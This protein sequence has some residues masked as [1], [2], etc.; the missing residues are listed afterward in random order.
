[1]FKL[2]QI[3]DKNEKSGMVTVRFERPEACGNCHACGYGSKS[4]EI[5]I[6][7]DHNVGD[8]VRVEFPENRFLQ[9]TALVYVIPLAGLLLGLALGWFLSDGNDL[10]TILSA[11][12]GLGVSFAALY[13]VDKSISKKPGWS[14]RITGVYADK[15]TGEEPGC[16]VS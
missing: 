11:A 6:A 2:G 4:S 1:M 7:S 13:G 5:A 14:P 9:A 12:L 16:G 8:W 10:V 3:T 15:P